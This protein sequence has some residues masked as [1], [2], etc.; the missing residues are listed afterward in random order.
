LDNLYNN[1]KKSLLGLYCNDPKFMQELIEVERYYA[2]YEGRAF[3]IEDDL[4]D[5]TGQLWAVKDRD[6][7]PTREV[8]NMT[9][10][11]MKKQGRFMT[12]VQPT[13]SLSS[14]QEIDLEQIDNKRALI[15]DIL[16]D[17][18]FWNKFSKAFLDC[19]IGKRVL[20]AVQTEVDEN[21][22]PLTD[23]P[24]KFRF[25]TMPEFTYQFDPNDCDKLIEVQIAYQD[26]DTV[27]KVPQEQRWHKWTYNMRDEYCWCVYEI[28]DGNNTLA[29]QEFN[30]N[31]VKLNLQYTDE[32]Y[33]I[34]PTDDNKIQIPLRSEW[35]TGFTQIPCKVILN[36]GLTGDT[37]G[38]SDIKDLMDLAMDYNKTVSDYRD[39]LRFKMFEQPV[40]IDCD[41]SSLENI[42]IAPNA[43]IDLKSDPAM[44]DGSS[45]SSIAKA[46]ML[47]STFNFTT[48]ADSYLTRLKQD[49]YELM[50]QPLPEN[51]V[52]VVSGKALKMLYYDLITR[53]EEKWSTWDEAL[54]WLVDIIE[55]AVLTFNMY[56]DKPN[57]NC[58]SLETIPAW[59]HNYPIPDDELDNKTASI[60]EVEAGVRS[61]KSY[62]EEFGNAEDAEAEFQRILDEQSQVNE[63]NNS[64]M[65]EMEEM[66]LGVKNDKEKEKDDEEEE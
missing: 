5:D 1:F 28:V 30:N 37:R 6:Y 2:F 23:N 34:S 29:F 18:K 27:G 14:A 40:F 47:S 53:C 59:L 49:M 54:E 39:A 63:V 41:S 8:R 48:A 66:K 17:G 45:A 4:Q 38:H 52:N 20:L 44:G 36:D 25:Y 22:Y 3:S 50:E 46:Q 31:E 16:D 7:R 55:E 24:L 10:K 26:V 57:I 35:N 62:I 65:F 11:L 32:N 61:K 13:L 19:T 64:A 12:S 15:E 21:G 33:Q 60:A 56:A 42:K 9:K 43:I 51:L 58:M